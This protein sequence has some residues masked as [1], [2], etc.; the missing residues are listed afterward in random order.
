[1]GQ[2]RLEH[3]SLAFG[4]LPEPQGV[5]LF[6]VDGIGVDR[7]DRVEGLEFDVEI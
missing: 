5:G 2:R 6:L 3:L 1:M 7:V 4:S